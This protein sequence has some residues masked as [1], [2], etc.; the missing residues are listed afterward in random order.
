M[1]SRETQTQITS[2]SSQQPI[3]IEVCGGIASGKTTF[4]TLLSRAGIE[5]VL[6]NFQANPF[7]ELFYSDSD[8]YA[9]ETEITFLL[10]HYNQIKAQSAYC[11]TLICDFSLYLDLAYT[12][13]TLHGSKYQVFRVVYDEVQRDLMPISLLVYLQCSAN[14]ELQRIRSRD[15]LAEKSITIEYLDKINKSL[16]Q[17]VD[18][19]GAKIK[20]IRIDS[21]KVNFAT[22]ERVRNDMIN[23]ILSSLCLPQTIIEGV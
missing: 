15:R 10:Q 20:I 5:A 4:A 13:V 8:K 18:E 23:L 22:D 3:R 14:T 7:L 11:R 17:H 1:S 21:E 2:S 6:E 9:F 19:V 16:E 12:A